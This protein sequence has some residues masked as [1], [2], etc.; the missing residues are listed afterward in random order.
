MREYDQMK[1]MKAMSWGGGAWEG[2]WGK[3][4]GLPEEI[5]ADIVGGRR[6]RGEKKRKI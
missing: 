1:V 4:G 3:R 5:R 2:A 6:R